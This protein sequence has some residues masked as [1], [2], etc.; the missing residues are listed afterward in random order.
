M[1]L[2]VLAAVAGLEWA[3]RPEISWRS[4]ALIACLGLLPTLLWRRSR[5]LAM[6]VIAFGVIGL[7]ALAELS[8]GADQPSMHTS[9]FVLLLPH[10]LLRWGS[11]REVAAGLPVMLMP[12]G[13]GLAADRATASDVIGGFAVLLAAGALGLAGRYR[14]GARAREIEQVR[15]RER[16]RLA[17]DLHDTVAHHVS[18]IAVRA[19]AGLATAPAN[20]AAALEAL[21]VIETEAR[22]TL[23]EMR[24][25]VRVLRNDEIPD[26][27]PSPTLGDLRRLA[28][29]EGP[30]VDLDVRGDV[31]DLSPAVSAAVYRLAQESIT[32][33]RRHARNASR[34]AVELAADD[35]HV[36]LRITDDGEPAAAPTSP[37]VGYGLAGMTERAQLLGGTFQA[38]PGLARGW[39]VTAVLPRKGPPR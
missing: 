37:A 14:A 33:V 22:R 21:G 23:S 27:L 34:I 32:N 26:L 17:R 7:V 1:L 36:R 13:L 31:D 18:A 28:D 39:T 15:L 20:P 25:M 29:G 3:G 16:E 12:A 2:G 6:V 10:A 11:G 35:D 38:G 19:Q 5:P 8:T 30:V 4:P 9:A 24:A